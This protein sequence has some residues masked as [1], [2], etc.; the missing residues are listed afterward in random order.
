MFCV[1]SL[2]F[3]TQITALLACGSLLL[4][5]NGF[6]VSLLYECIVKVLFCYNRNLQLERC[7]EMPFKSPSL[8]S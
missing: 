5:S 2:R 1:S 6:Y 3:E 8:P 7:L 4:D